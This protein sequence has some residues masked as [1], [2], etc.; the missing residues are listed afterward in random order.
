MIERDLIV[1]G[2]GPGGYPA[3]AA[4]AAQ[5]RKVTVIERG[6]PGGTCLNRGCIP[7]KCLA[8]T[9][10]VA[11]TAREAAGFGILTGET[12]VDYG[13]AV[14]RKNE[15][16]AGLREGVKAVLGGV[17]T[18]EGEA[19]IV[20]GEPLQVAVGNDVYTA[21]QVIIATGSEP[22]RLNIPGAELA[23]TSDEILDL[24]ELPAS[25]AVI[26]GGVIG[27][28]FASIFAA[29]GVE[30]TV[31]EYCKEV[32]PPFDSEIAKRL[33]MALK[34][35]GVSFI[36]G[37]EVT[38]MRPGIEIDY[39]A[40]GKTGYVVAEAVLMA[41]GRK[42]VIPAGTTEAGVETTRRGI[43][44]NPQ[45]MESSVKGLYAVGDVNGLCQLAHAATAQG[46]RA[47]GEDVDLEP[48]P[49][50]VFTVPEAAMS[51]LTEAQA[52]AAGYKV[53]IGKATFRS[54]GKALA[55]GDAEGMV[56]V[57]IDAD[58]DRILGAHI[59]GLHAADLIHELSLA[60]AAG[61]TAGQLHKAV[62]AHPTLAE[63]VAH[64]CK[65]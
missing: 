65:A 10:E 24:R 43:S 47:V 35:R 11:L 26:G 25:L 38:A 41:V 54:N 15:V 1:I 55:E 19:R 20:S 17:E 6:L 44:V 14:D 39:T 63:T 48:V 23:M 30:V 52:E 45:T 4:A 36:L 18:V 57:V 2:S 21:P 29:L 40:K 9:A 33:R 7:T 58:T 46:L 56:K 34:K 22:V 42:A 12:R 13:R 16:I 37:A 61:V 59:L 27:L 5:G 8:R 53:K 51:G 32:L 28:E 64:A 62:H 3:A 60:I 49:S 31:I 50:A